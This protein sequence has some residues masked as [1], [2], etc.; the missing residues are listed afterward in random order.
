ML[1][2][3]AVRLRLLGFD[4]TYHSDIE[5]SL[6]LRRSREENRLLLTR[7]LELTKTRGANAYFVA[8]RKLLDQL[9]EVIGRFKLD[10]SPDQ[11]FTRCSV[12][13]ELLIPVPKESVRGKVPPVVYKTFQQ[14]S[15]SP[16]CEHYYWKGS[17]YHRLL[18]EIES[19]L[20]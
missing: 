2:K 13:N 4:T 16:A 18:S 7:D 8:N 1:G 19:I 12:C 17:H 14:F 9:R 10:L 5:D 3:L 6:L 15:Y 11:F 20:K